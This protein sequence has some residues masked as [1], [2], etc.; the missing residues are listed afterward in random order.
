MPTPK[1]RSIT[2]ELPAHEFERL[3]TFCRYKG[4]AKAPL[5]R[6]AVSDYMDKRGFPL[7]SPG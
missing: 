5:L 6:L 2:L 1:K 3:E 7:R 4:V